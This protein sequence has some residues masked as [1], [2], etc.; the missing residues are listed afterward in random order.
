MAAVRYPTI[1]PVSIGSILNSPLKKMAATM[2]ATRVTTASHQVVSDMLIATGAS[3]IPITVITGPVTI[4]GKI[5]FTT[6]LPTNV[7]MTDITM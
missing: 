7:M 2:V 4:G 6:S 1:A 3:V 5:L